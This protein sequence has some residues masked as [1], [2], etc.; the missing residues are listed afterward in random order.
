MK[1]M[2]DEELMLSVNEIFVSVEGEGVRTGYLS[3]FIRLNGC[4]LKCSYCDTDYAHQVQKPNKTLRQILDEVNSYE[5]NRV[6]L[7]GGEPLLHPHVK[8]LV[9]NLAFAGYEVNIE[10]NGSVELG[11]YTQL[12]GVFVTMDWKCPSSGMN[13]RMLKTNLTKLGYS[14]V[15]KFVVQNDEDLKEFLKIY[16]MDLP[17]AYYLSPVYGKIEPKKIVEF[18]KEHKTKYAAAQ[19]QL[20]KIIWEP[21]QRGV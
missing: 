9:E 14:D 11:E 5:L 4:N 10:T 21:N 17:C 16:E 8:N 12:P 6:T 1:K 7:T 3:V 15:L 19:V 2:N 13:E 20:H 18:M